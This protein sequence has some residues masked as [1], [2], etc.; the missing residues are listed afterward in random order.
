MRQAHRA[1]EWLKARV[2]FKARR[3]LAFARLRVRTFT[4]GWRGLPDFL[5]IG[6]QRGGT[7]SLYKYLGQHP[8]V[9]P[10]L[11]KE[12]EYFSRFYSK[13]ESWYRAHFPLSA[14]R[15]A[16]KLTG[17]PLQAFEATPDYMLHPLAAE[18]AARLVPNA[19]II[20]LLRDPIERAYSQYKHNVRNG[21]ERRSF[22]TAIEQE[23]QRIA[24]EFELL[25]RDPSYPALGLLRDSYLTRG[26]YDEQLARW[27]EHYPETQILVLSS[28]EFYSA[29]P[30]TFKRILEFLELPDWAPAEF[31]NYS[32]SAAS[33][34]KSDSAVPDSLRAQVGD[35]MR[36]YNEKLYGRLG[37]DF[38]WS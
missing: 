28:E 37:R 8:S 1:A 18:R 14:R 11:R 23:P 22:D 24:T 21:Q 30:D 20:V 5:V 13:G 35:E 3:K 32:Y 26:R 31:A 25:G 34:S 4:A 27:S 16:W 33:P 2:S 6:V 38:G 10:S 7:S 17:K 15:W 19:K 12:T 29:T 9:A 36:P